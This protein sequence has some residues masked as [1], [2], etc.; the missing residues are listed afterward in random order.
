MDLDSDASS[1]AR[2][3]VRDRVNPV[4]DFF[5]LTSRG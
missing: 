5:D 1:I 3:A 2:G 4:P